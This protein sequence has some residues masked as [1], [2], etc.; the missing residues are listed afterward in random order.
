[1]S[2][3]PC[4]QIRPF[5]Y[6]ASAV[7]LSGKPP[8]GMAFLSNHQYLLQNRSLPRTR[9]RGQ[10]A[11]RKSPSTMMIC[12]SACSIFSRSFSI[13]FEHLLVLLGAFGLL[14]F[15][16]FVFTFLFSASR[17]R[18]RSAARSAPRRNARRHDGILI[19]GVCNGNILVLDFGV[20]HR[21][22]EFRHRSWRLLRLR[23]Q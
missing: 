19:V 5:A 17:F 22:F 1:M 21:V 9:V 2:S 7:E 10:S 13:C 3:G 14:F 18:L 4:T 6:P 15:F 12:S 11:S 23:R 16:C 20:F 8:W